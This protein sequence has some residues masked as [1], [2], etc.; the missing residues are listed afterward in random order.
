MPASWTP[1]ATWDDHPPRRGLGYLIDASLDSLSISCRS[2]R[3]STPPGHSSSL[4]KDPGSVIEF[5]QFRIERFFRPQRLISTNQF[6]RSCSSRRFS[7][8]ATFRIRP[9]GSRISGSRSTFQ[10]KLPGGGHSSRSEIRRRA[11][12]DGRGGA[13]HLSFLLLACRIWEQSSKPV[14]PHKKAA[15]RKPK[16]SGGILPIL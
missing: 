3:P 16:A 13:D 6:L 11:R 4:A 12:R 8:L 2:L 1:V 5:R 15:R 10:S 7:L 9:H 14:R